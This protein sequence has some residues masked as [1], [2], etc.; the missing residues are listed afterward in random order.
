[1]CFF[2]T[3]TKA[4]KIPKTVEPDP[5]IRHEANASL[6]KTSLDSPQ[7]TSKQAIN[8]SIIGLTDENL[9]PKKTLLGE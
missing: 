2:K 8:H 3:K 5:V 4:P 9:D 6:T 1:M 7:S